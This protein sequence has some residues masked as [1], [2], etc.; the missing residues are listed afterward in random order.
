ML[1][2]ILLFLRGNLCVGLLLAMISICQAQPYGLASR[3]AVGAFLNNVMPEA[4]PVVSTNWAVAPAFP[5]LYFTNIIGV[6]P[7]PGTN[8]LCVWEQIGRAH[9]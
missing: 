9:V 7:V 1:S 4:A 8:L 6:L 3:P 5:N 2:R